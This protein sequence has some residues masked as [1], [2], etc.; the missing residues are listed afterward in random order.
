MQICLVSRNSRSQHC[1]DKKAQ[2]SRRKHQRHCQWRSHFCTQCARWHL[3]QSCVNRRCRIRVFGLCQK[4]TH[5][6]RNDNCHQ[7]QHAITPPVEN[8]RHPRFVSVQ[9]RRVVSLI[10]LPRPRRIEQDE[11]RDGPVQHIEILFLAQVEWINE[12]SPF[13]H[14]EHR[15]FQHRPWKLCKQPEAD[16][17]E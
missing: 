14:R 4:R 3:L 12:G 2:Y 6:K 8:L 1:C 10:T 9:R 13:G 5:S 7:H 17:H 15:A 16:E 11:C